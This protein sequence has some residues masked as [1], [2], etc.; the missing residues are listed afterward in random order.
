V[1][2]FPRIHI[3]LCRAASVLRRDMHNIRAVSVDIRSSRARPNQYI[4]QYINYV[5]ILREEEIMT[6][7]IVC[8]GVALWLGLNVAFVA[9]R[10]HVTRPKRIAV[11]VLLWNRP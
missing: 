1:K 3:N 4:N 7:T 10:I 8:T 2:K 6:S 11:P 5:R 9:L